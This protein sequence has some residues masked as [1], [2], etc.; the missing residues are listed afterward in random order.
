MNATNRNETEGTATVVVRRNACAVCSH[1]R[2]AEFDTALAAGAMAQTDVALLVGCHKSSVSRHVKNHLVPEVSVAVRE[3]SELADMNVDILAGLRTLYRGIQ[4]LLDRVLSAKDAETNWR[5]VCALNSETRNNLAMLAKL[6]LVLDNRRQADVL[7]SDDYR[8]MRRLLTRGLQEHPL[9]R[10]SIIAEL[11]DGGDVALDMA[12]SLDAVAWAHSLGFAPD[13]WQEEVLRSTSNRV[14]MC[15]SRQSGKSETAALLALHTALYDE[16]A[17]VLLVSPSLRQSKE[18]FR[19]VTDWLGKVSYTIPMEE[20]TT[21]SCEFASGSRIVCLPGTEATVRG[22]SKAKLIIEDEASR[23]PDEYFNALRP[24]LAVSQGRLLLLSTPRGRRGHFSDRWH[25]KSDNWQRT[26]VTAYEC[27]RI[28]EEFLA[29]EL[30][31]IGRFWFDQEYLVEFK[32]AT[33]AYFTADVI[34]MAFDTDV[35]PFYS[36]EY[37]ASVYTEDR[38]G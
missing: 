33:D 15:A 17:L 14:I 26:K 32:E 5:A 20:D 27:P 1:P 3:D 13:V 16:G 7:G 28:T 37:L 2:R 24:M 22:Y 8:D 4:P 29:A 25:D 34:E 6:L 23:V 21:T 11:M 30:E 18:L 9:A 31:E 19:K 36:D 12:Y 10:D 35:A 38:G